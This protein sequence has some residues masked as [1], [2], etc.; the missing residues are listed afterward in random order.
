LGPPFLGPCGKD[1][2]IYVEEK[3]EKATLYIY[4]YKDVIIRK[5]P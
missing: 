1:E 4:I 5:G 3:R 2:E